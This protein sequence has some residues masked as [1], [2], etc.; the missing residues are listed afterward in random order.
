MGEGAAKQLANLQNKLG[1]INWQLSRIE[2]KAA[3]PENEGKYTKTIL[4]LRKEKTDLDK[5]IESTTNRLALEK[6]KGGAN[7]Q[8]TY[9][10]I[11]LKKSLP[12]DP[13]INAI[14]DTLN[15]DIKSLHTSQKD[16]TGNSARLTQGMVGAAVCASC[17]ETQAEF[18]KT[19]PHA[20]AYNTLVKGNRQFDL[21]CLA[22]H[23]TLNT[24]SGET[25]VII[26]DT[27]Y[28]SYPVEL[29]SVGCESCH[30]SGK[31]H[32]IDP[33]M[34]TLSLQPSETVCLTCHTPEHSNTFDYALQLNQV[35]CPK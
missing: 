31:K 11:G 22:C 5:Q 9:R 28:L 2:K 26:N 13:S 18:W 32:S 6:T 35:S 10:F 3:A 24:S 12:N 30:G 29:Q 19:T 27:G 16:Q 33:E 1:S 17:H 21:N 7:D 8:F 23:L 20:S 25:G 14:L 15:K 34:F 4:R